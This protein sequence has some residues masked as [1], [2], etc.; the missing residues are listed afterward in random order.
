MEVN[1]EYRIWQLNTD[2]FWWI[3][4]WRLIKRTENYKFTNFEVLKILAD[5]R[6]AVDRDFNLHLH[7]ILDF[8]NLGIISELPTYLILS[9]IHPKV[10]FFNLVFYKAFPHLILAF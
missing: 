9:R 5:Y 10:Q 4:E 6:V 3:I 8:V 1:G 2:C 7:L